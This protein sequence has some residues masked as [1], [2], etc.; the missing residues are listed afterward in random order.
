MAE[1]VATALGSCG[2]T[3]HVYRQPA[4]IANASDEAG[5]YFACETC[6]NCGPI[7]R[8]Y[9]IAVAEA[10][11]HVVQPHNHQEDHSGD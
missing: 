7:N 6:G 8:R 9:G 5:Y 11:S 2:I 3:A 4:G 1:R 10:S